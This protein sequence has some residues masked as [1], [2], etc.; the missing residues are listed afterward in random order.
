MWKVHGKLRIRVLYN[1]AQVGESTFD[2][3]K[4]TIGR[5]PACDLVIDNKLVSGRHARIIRADA[6]YII[7]DL[8]S[9]NGTQLGGRPVKRE[10]L[11]AGA[12]ATIGKHQLEFFEEGES[13]GGPGDAR[14]TV[15]PLTEQT[16]AASPEEARELYAKISLDAYLKSGGKLAVL[17]MEKGKGFPEALT[18]KKELTIVGKDPAAD[19]S[20]SGFLQP[21]VAFFVER[22]RNGY[23]LVPLETSN[24]VRLNG[25]RLAGKAA[26]GSGD[27][28][29]VGSARFRF[30][31]EG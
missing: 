21:A 26:L 17:R 13:A 7:E 3:D 9:T 28:I 20:V 23:S 18:L 15:V 27:E 1:G 10:I 11:R 24:K 29:L 31:L 4:I 8:D 6:G 2:S 5:D 22:T 12:R 25:K 19:L 16:L 14:D 30:T